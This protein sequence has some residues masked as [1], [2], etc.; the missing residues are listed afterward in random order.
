MAADAEA[1]E[2]Y[3]QAIAAYEKSA[4]KQWDPFQRAVIERKI[5]EALFRRGNHD[6]A[7]ESLHRSLA[8]LGGRPYPNSRLAVRIQI[9]RELVKQL[10]HRISVIWHRER[11]SKTINQVDNERSRIYEAMGW[12][13]YFVDQECLALD[14][15]LLL[16]LSEKAGLTGGE[17]QGLSGL[18]CIFD[19][20][21]IFHLAERYHRRAVSR[22]EQSSDPVSIGH[23]FVFFGVHE[24][25][26]GR[27]SS[28][29]KYYNDAAQS[30]QD[31]G[32]L[33]GW[34]VAISCSAMISA[35]HG[36]LKQKRQ[37][38]HDL[39]RAGQDAGDPQIEGWGIAHLSHVMAL[40]GEGSDQ[41][42]RLA[43]NALEIFSSIPDYQSVA[44]IT[45]GLGEINCRYGNAQKALSIMR[46]SLQIISERH[47]RSLFL[48][49]SHAHLAE[50]LLA[51]AEVTDYAERRSIMRETKRACNVVL[52]QSKMFKGI[53]A[54]A[55]RLE[56]TYQWLNGNPRNARKWWSRSLEAAKKL[57][58]NYELGRSHFEIGQRTGELQHLRNAESIFA[59]IGC[60]L[61]LMQTRQCLNSRL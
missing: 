46:E 24:H 55:F 49:E 20:V 7:L 9:V 11:P 53:E 59:E 8:Y 42:C 5:G 29:L 1:L 6:R 40:E 33:R 38:A 18:G 23:A 14:I 4:D 25:Q 48:S 16:N 31:G 13:H 61:D 50:A 47:L 10:G 32:N 17:V 3:H 57:G 56:G 60:N 58:A 15:L 30:Y 19:L 41:A 27:L 35:S 39:I 45:A 28:A 44:A 37:H 43:E 2:H 22:A 34:G 51:V 36:N 12:I 54:E 21:P 26:L 52:S